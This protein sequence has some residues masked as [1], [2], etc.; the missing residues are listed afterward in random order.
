MKQ[1]SVSIAIKAPAGM[2]WSLLTNAAGYPTWNT[3]VSKVDVT[4]APGHTITVH[5]KAAGRALAP[6]P[7]APPVYTEKGAISTGWNRNISRPREVAGLALG[8]GLGPGNGPA[9]ARLQADFGSLE[10]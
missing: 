5:A 7:P 8:G 4:I 9:Q 10:S 6:L 1:F 3:T 2:I